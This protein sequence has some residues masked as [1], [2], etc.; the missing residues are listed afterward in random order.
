MYV[1]LIRAGQ[2]L[3]LKEETVPCKST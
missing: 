2:T 3:Y 1:L